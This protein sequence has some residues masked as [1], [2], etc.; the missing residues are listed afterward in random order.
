[1]IYLLTGHSLYNRK[2]HPFVL[3]SC[4]RGEGIKE[5]HVC[6]MISHE[7]TIEMWDKSRRVWNKKLT[8]LKP[9]ETYDKKKHM[10]FVNKPLL[11]ISHFGIHPEFLRRDRIRF[12]VFHLRCAVTRRIIAYICDFILRSSME[13]WTVAHICLKL[14]SQNILCWL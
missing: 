1:M 3:C 13:C 11:G 6:K 12:D 5:G 9:G 4:Q 8:K 2:Y 14:F 10:D 7:K